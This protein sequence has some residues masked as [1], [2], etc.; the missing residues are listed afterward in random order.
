MLS[1][2]KPRCTL[3]LAGL[4]AAACASPERLVSLDAAATDAAFA[5]AAAYD[6]IDLGGAPAGG[7]STA[8][9]ISDHGHVLI[10]SQ[11]FRGHLA[12]YFLWDNG[13][14]T[15]LGSINGQLLNGVA[16]NKHGAVTGFYS[17]SGGYDV[18]A[19]LWEN[20]TVTDLGSRGAF[21]SDYHNR[22]AINDRGQ[23]LWFGFSVDANNTAVFQPY[24]WDKGSITE[25]GSLVSP[26]HGFSIPVAMND[27]GDVVGW[28]TRENGQGAFGHA[29]LWRDGVMTDLGAFEGTPVI[30]Y[31]E[32]AAINDKGQIAGNSVIGNGFTHPFLWENGVMT[33]LGGMDGGVTKAVAI[34][35]SGQIVGNGARHAFS[36]TA[37]GGMVDL[38]F[39]TVAVDVNDAGQVVGWSSTAQRAFMWQDGVMTDLG[40]LGSGFSQ[41]TAI[42]NRGV[43]IGNSATASYEGRAT[44]W[45][46]RSGNK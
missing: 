45:V 14:L 25:L 20:G 16:V 19:F 18:N 39:G 43:I 2:R 10:R 36:W 27:R 33:D 1:S 3:I 34:N 4:V 37:A 41:A 31:S 29:F 35:A 7:I 6:V 44:M 24:L 46:P 26:A 15:E 12:G 5:R 28:S 32:P 13:S 42:N 30:N 9:A 40:S 38:G 21:N 11:G 23:V 8:V 17:P 22:M